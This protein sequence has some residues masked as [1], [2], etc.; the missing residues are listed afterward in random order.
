[1]TYWGRSAEAGSGATA[2][3]VSL[4]MLVGG[5]TGVSLGWGVSLATDVADGLGV[6]LGSGVSVG[7]EGWKGVLEACGLAVTST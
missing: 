6:A 3:G 5:V 2:A 4:G 7:A 1:M